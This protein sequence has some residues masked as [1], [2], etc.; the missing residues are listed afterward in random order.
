MANLLQAFNRKTITPTVKHG[1]G[2]FIF[3][4]SF[5]YGTTTNRA[6]KMVRYDLV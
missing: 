2:N 1:D 4:G 3:G 5:F 6:L